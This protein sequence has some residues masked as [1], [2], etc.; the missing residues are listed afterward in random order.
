[1]IVT[2]IV[3][4]LF[5]V[6]LLAFIFTMAND[7]GVDT[8]ELQEQGLNYQALNQSL[9]DTQ[10]DVEEFQ[11]VFQRGNIF[12]VVAGIVVEGIFDIGNDM[13]RM[14]FGNG[15]LFEIIFIDSARILGIPSIVVGTIIAILILVAIFGLWRLLKQGD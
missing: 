4:M 6:L 1:M 7:Y 5:A 14:V 8:T 9:Y 2:S 10:Q 11:Q 12:S 3:V 15:G 13:F